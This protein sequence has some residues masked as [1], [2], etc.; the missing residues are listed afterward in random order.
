VPVGG[1]GGEDGTLY[2]RTGEWFAWVMLGGTALVVAG[3]LAA[4]RGDRGR[5]VKSVGSKGQGRMESTNGT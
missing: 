2:G 3:S 1:N 4:G 5:D